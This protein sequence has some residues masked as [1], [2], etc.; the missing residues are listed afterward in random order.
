MLLSMLD[1]LGQVIVL[2][3]VG[4]CRIYTPDEEDYVYI[5]HSSTTRLYTHLYYRIYIYTV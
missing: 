3:L 1:Y 5:R 2:F 4:E